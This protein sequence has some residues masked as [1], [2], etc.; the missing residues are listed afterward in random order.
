[1]GKILL[2]EDDFILSETLKEI[3]ENENFSVDIAHNGEEAYKLTFENSYD[4]YLFDIN[5]PDENGIEILKNLR[6]S[7]DKT[8]T[9]YI[10]AL[11]DIE[12]IGKAFDSGAIDYI[13]K[14]FDPEELLIRIKSKFKTQTQI[15]KYKNLEYN[16]QNQELKKDNKIINLGYIQK[17]IFHLLITNPNQIIPK[18]ELLQFLE[19]QNENAL[20]VT[21]TKLKKKLDIEIKAIRG[22]GY[23]IESV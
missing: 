2:L 21:I 18:S 23:I 19:S 5:L 10:T 16:P 7:D 9:I 8:A 22:E 6:D 11:I 4:L 12:T 13:K 14:P 17:N 1:M 20:R 15:I 3:L